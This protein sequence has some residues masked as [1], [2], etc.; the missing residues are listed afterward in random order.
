MS[1][2]RPLSGSV[3]RAASAREAKLLVVLADARA[4]NFGGGEVERGTAN[5]AQL[6]GGDE[7]RVHGREARR[8]KL[9][10]VPEDVSAA[11]PREIEVGVLGEIHRRRLVGG[12]GEVDHEL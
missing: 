10:L 11:G 4:D 2:P 3:N 8:A 5:A 7:R 6:A 1:T 12:G 9:Q